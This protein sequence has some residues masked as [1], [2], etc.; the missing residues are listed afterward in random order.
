MKKIKP[1]KICIPSPFP[2]QDSKSLLWKY[3]ATIFVGGKE[4]QFSDAEIVNIA[5]ISGMTR[6]NHVFALKYNPKV[7]QTPVVVPTPPPRL[8]AS[9]VVPTIPVKTPS[10][11]LLK[12]TSSSTSE[13][14]IS[15]GKEVAK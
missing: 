7:I 10:S 1:I 2:Y 4:I 8:G 11:F 14:A 6:N 15:K 13:A 9:V 3:H 5:G 12:G